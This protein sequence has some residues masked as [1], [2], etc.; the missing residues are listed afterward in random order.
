MYIW[1][2][3]L[4]V[5]WHKRGGVKVFNYIEQFCFIKDKNYIDVQKL[6]AGCFAAII[7]HKEDIWKY[8]ILVTLNVIS[9]MV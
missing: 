5:T 6:T 2:T 9:I 8:T 7:Q 1:F 3:R 4:F